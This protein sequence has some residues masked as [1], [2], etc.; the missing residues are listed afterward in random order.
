MVSF[1]KYEATGNDFII[2]DQCETTAELAHLRALAPKLCDRHFGIGADGILLID[3]SQQPTRMRIINADGSLAETCGNG[4]R[5]A[6]RYLHEHY[7]LKYSEFDILSDAGVV[8]ARILQSA[9]RGESYVVEVELGGL[10]FEGKRQIKLGETLFD[11]NL[12]NVGNPHAVVFVDDDPMSWAQKHGEALSTHASFAAGANI[13]FVR[14][15]GAKSAQ[16]A[17]YER[18]AGLTLA[19]G[20]GSIATT[21]VFIEQFAKDASGIELFLP[22]GRVEVHK[23]TNCDAC[24]SLRGE[25][26]FVFRGEWIKGMI[27]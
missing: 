7:A 17:V 15:L 16:M 22:G 14:R 9:E 12:I 24:Y 25:V 27:S 11:L 5:C 8:K 21:A 18:G 6:A 13:E 3:A 23:S 4:L 10:R 1:F 26:N 20:S 19:C 2:V